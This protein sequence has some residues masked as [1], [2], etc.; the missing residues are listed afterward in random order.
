LPLGTIHASFDGES[1]EIR[2]SQYCPECDTDAPEALISEDE[3][4]RYWLGQDAHFR[5]KIACP[6]TGWTVPTSFVERPFIDAH[7][8]QKLL[9]QKRFQRDD[10]LKEDLRRR[11]LARAEQQRRSQEWSRRLEEMR[12]QRIVEEQERKAQTQ[13]RRAEAELRREEELYAKAEGARAM[14]QDNLSNEARAIIQDKI[15]RELWLNS[16]NPKLR[17]TASSQPLRPIESA[18]ES[19]EGLQRA[20]AVLRASKTP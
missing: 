4:L 1:E 3:A 17:K 20:L 6:G 7:K 11:E 18:G 15:R 5:L 19:T 13:R 2:A 14:R 10:Q 16:S 9:E 12:L 8:W